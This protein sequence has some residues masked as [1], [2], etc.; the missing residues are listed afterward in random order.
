MP[1]LEIHVEDGP[2]VPLGITI[3]GASAE[4][5]PGLVMIIGVKNGAVLHGSTKEGCP[6]KV[7]DA[8]VSVNGVDLHESPSF[9]KSKQLI[10]AAGRPVLLGIETDL[11]STV[12]SRRR[13]SAIAA[14][15]VAS[16]WVER[17]HNGRTF[18]GNK[19]TKGTTWVKPVCLQEARSEPAARAAETSAKP[20]A[21]PAPSPS[22]AAAKEEV[23]AS[24]Q[25]PAGT[26]SRA[27]SL[28]SRL[29]RS[30]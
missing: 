7:G 16:N 26:P 6:I 11:K 13:K 3:D 17:E 15:D 5:A 8:I 12:E 28:P 30:R 18:W 14:E 29:S 10:I 22:S 23:V 21:K 20:A 4:Y 1:V 27:S 24:P 9:A 25:E 19:V 2:E